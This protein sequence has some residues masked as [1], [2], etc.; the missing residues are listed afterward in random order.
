MPAM[1]PRAQ[2]LEFFAANIRNKNT[3]MADYQAVDQLFAR[4]D[5][6]RIGGI[7]DVRAVARGGL[8]RQPGGDPRAVPRARHKPRF[9]LPILHTQCAI[10]SMS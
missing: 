2:F 9:L 4:C 6:H 1:R 5:R 7:A 3:R 10:K 8:H